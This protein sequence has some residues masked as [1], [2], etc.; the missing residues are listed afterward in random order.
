MSEPTIERYH[1]R[2][3]ANRVGMLVAATRPAFLT[4][5][6]LPVL[7]GS[8]LAALTST[9]AVPPPLIALAAVDIALVHAGANV[10]NDYFD[11]ASGNDRANTAFVHPFSGGSRFIQNAVLSEGETLRFG[12]MLMAAGA[13]LGT[14]VVGIGG[15]LL[16]ALGLVGTLLAVVYSSP[17]C[18]ACR[19]LGDVVIGICFGLLPVAG[20]TLLLTGSIPIEAWWLGGV[21]ACFVAA[22]LWVN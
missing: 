14:L 22:I 10:L 16:L 3:L 17:P 8:A 2:T 20:M 9:D 15:P 5:S 18:L 13:A 1:R 21:I 7:A 11:S 19:G 6:V 4:A 12:V